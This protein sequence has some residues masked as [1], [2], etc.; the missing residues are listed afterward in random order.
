MDSKYDKLKKIFDQCEWT[1]KYFEILPENRDEVRYEWLEEDADYA[2]PFFTTGI[3]K[4]KTSA[5]KRSLYLGQDE[6]GAWKLCV[7]EVTCDDFDPREVARG[8]V[9]MMDV[10]KV[11]EANKNKGLH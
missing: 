6:N 10:S 3:L 1:E 7:R 2:R 5:V 8:L 4:E 11:V 9:R